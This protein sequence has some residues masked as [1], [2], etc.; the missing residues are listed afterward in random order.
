MKL[1]LIVLS[2]DSNCIGNCVYLF[3]VFVFIFYFSFKSSMIHVAGEG[4]F[5]KFHI[6]VKCGKHYDYQSITT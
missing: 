6:V 3:C 5:I 2:L 1:F 4:G